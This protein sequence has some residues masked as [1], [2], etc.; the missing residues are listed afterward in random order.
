MLR[1]EFFSLTVKVVLGLPI[2]CD[3]ISGQ[4]EIGVTVQPCDPN[5]SFDKLQQGHAATDL[6]AVVI[7]L[8]VLL[9]VTIIALI[10][11]TRR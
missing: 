11:V 3:I 7:V 2:H 10:A 9:A 4:P 5:A 8:A 6:L 1:S